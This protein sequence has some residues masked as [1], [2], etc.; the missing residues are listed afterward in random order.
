M[1]RLWRCF[2]IGSRP[3]FVG[4]GRIGTSALPRLSTWRVVLFACHAI[5]SVALTW[6]GGAH[7]EASRQAVCTIYDQYDGPWNFCLRECI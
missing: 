3:V 1:A 2:A 7:Q 4:T 5:L 6:T